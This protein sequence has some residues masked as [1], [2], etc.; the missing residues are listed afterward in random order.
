MTKQ[1]ETR[2]S[3]GEQDHIVPQVFFPAI[4]TLRDPTYEGYLYVLGNMLRTNRYGAQETR[5]GKVHNRLVAICFADGE[6][7]SNLRFSQAIYDELGSEQTMPL[8]PQVVFAAAGKAFGT[9]IAQEPI[10]CEPK[11][12]GADIELL[13]E[14]V[15]RLYQ[16]KDKLAVV[17]KALDDKTRTYASKYGKPAKAPKKGK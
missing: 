6:I 15:T 9:L 10:H 5:T 1:G 2:S 8:D 12:I 13:V 7:F 17:L 4:E 14:D 16:D 11:I 3:F